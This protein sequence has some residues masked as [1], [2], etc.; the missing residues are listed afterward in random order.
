MTVSLSNVILDRPLAALDLETTG[1]DPAA[2]RLVE[3]AVLTVLPGGGQELFHRRVNPGVPI[4]PAATA[5]HGIGDA[6][7]AGAPPF[8]AIA[9][10]LF[11]TLHGC[12]LAGFGIATFDLPLLSAEFARVRIPFRVAGRRVIDVLALYRRLQ[13]RTLASAVRE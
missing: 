8:G 13:P 6:D 2:D 3:V 4:P 9:P 12:D 5:V 10:E 11:A 1:V 7:V